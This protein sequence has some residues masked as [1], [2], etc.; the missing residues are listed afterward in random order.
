[1]LKK[2]RS[3]FARTKA[4]FK[5]DVNEILFPSSLPDPP[6]VPHRRPITIRE[7]FWCLKEAYLDYT[8][9]WKEI[10]KRPVNV[11]PD[12]EKTQRKEQE[13]ESQKDE[14]PTLAEELA[15][16]A[17]GGADSMKPALQKIYYSRAQVFRDSALAFVEGYK[18]GLKE[19]A[20]SKDPLANFGLAAQKNDIETSRS[21]DAENSSTADSDKN[22]SGKNGGGGGN[23]Q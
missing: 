1:M 7:F 5:H 16:A 21:A 18:D 13:A 23:R 6:G 20:E 14:G 10:P 8:D 19:V 4:Y 3:L 17:R 22:L 12:E 11:G 15:A 9:S 2:V